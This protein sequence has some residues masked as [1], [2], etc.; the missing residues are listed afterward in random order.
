MIIASRNIR[1][2]LAD[3]LD[4]NAVSIAGC[5]CDFGNCTPLGSDGMQVYFASTADYFKSGGKLLKNSPGDA[6]AAKRLAEFAAAE[7]PEAVEGNYIAAFVRDDSMTV[8]TDKFGKSELYYFR[9]GDD[10]LISDS[11]EPFFKAGFL[12]EYDQVA[13]SNFF[14]VYGNY[15]PKKHTLYKNIK[16][17]GI[18]EYFSIG[19]GT[20][21]VHSFKT[22]HPPIEEYSEEKLNEYCDIFTSA[23]QLRSTESGVNWVYLSSGWDST[24]ILAVLKSLYSADKIRCVIAKCIYTERS[25]VINQFEVDRAKEIADYYGVQLDIVTIDYTRDETAEYFESI[26]PFLRDSHTFS[27]NCV[28]FSM[29]ADHVHKHAGPDDVVFSGEISDGVHNLGF[30]QYATI[31]DHPDLNFRE[32]ADKMA[33]YLYSPSFL[34]S[35]LKG[36]HD[37]DIIY[38]FLRSRYGNAQFDDV[39]GNDTDKKIGLLTSFYLSSRRIP[40][41]SISNH[42]LL[43]EKAK[44]EYLAEMQQTYLQEIVKEMTPENL[45]AVMIHLY[46]S[47]HWQ[48]STVK[49]LAKALERYGRTIQ[50]PFWDSRLQEFLK[51]MPES[52]GRGLDLNNTKFPLKW[53]LKNKIDYPIHLQKGPHSYL[54][55]VNPGFSIL[56]EA[57]NGSAL[58][59]VFHSR[60]QGKPYKAI[61]NEEYFDMAY[62]DRCVDAYLN[63]EEL[64]GNELNDL[65]SVILLSAIL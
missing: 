23:V 2:R 12:K 40:L 47:F 19:N 43:T 9:D 17:L 33:S 13:L 56:S 37:R 54:Y 50:L 55:D 26:L 22:T 46:N 31:L 36:T 61:M 8:I 58:K 48:G 6:D 44:Q 15:P 53:I 65:A 41:Y 45:Y 28:N 5:I 34:Q 62:I 11:L 30:S 32:Y 38:N 7:V 4:K 16:R 1:E 24:S 64:K 10:F 20:L 59:K 39:P 3:T 63:G 35:I 21:T 18:G 49:V 42:T 14:L 60:L 27:F 57:V 29:L 51:K 52:W 25:G